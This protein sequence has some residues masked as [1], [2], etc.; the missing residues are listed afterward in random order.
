MELLLPDPWQVAQV[1]APAL[2]A[3]SEDWPDRLALALDQP[4][5]GPPLS[6]LLAARPRGRVV[7]V[8][9]DVTRHSPIPRVL[10]VVLRELRHAGV[11]DDRIEVVFA[12]GMHPPMTARQAADKLG[13]AGGVLR[14]RSNPYGDR[15][16]YEYLGRVGKV[17]VWIDRGVAAADVR[18]IISS[19]SPHLQAGFGGGWKML[20]PGCAHCETIRALHRLGPGREFA[21]LVGLPAPENAMRAAIDAGGQLLASA[22]GATY[23]VQFLLDEADRPAFITAGEVVPAHQMLTK[24][25]AVACGVTV[26][27]PAD[28]VITNAWPRDFDLW[29]SFKCIP[30]T[31]WAARPGG[32]VI[33][34]T[35]CEAGAY[36][37]RVP[38]WPISPA[39][40]RWLIRRLGANTVYSL[41]TRLVP[42]LAGDAAFFVR[43]AAHTITRNAVIM[44]SPT[45][46]AAAAEFPGL[47]IVGTMEQAVARAEAI[48]PPG[49]RR[50]T[51]FPAGGITY[52]V[53]PAGGAE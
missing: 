33:C 35:R 8:V 18:V 20:L 19:T 32:V 46:H 24:Q 6:R 45:L 47:E 39:R 27:E 2:R 31:L 29:Q 1:A 40:T 11:G 5:A 30:N 42:S 41:L 22:G 53:S 38:A 36:G 7:L 50:V 12:T 4:V 14:W 28:V 3:A 23:S 10:E 17:P 51:V 21:R 25:C 43:L 13:P 16:A 9:E 26:A 15:S 48:L 37:M 34:L 44:V 52:P 49:R